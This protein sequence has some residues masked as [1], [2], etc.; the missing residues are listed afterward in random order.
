MPE[1]S[2]FSLHNILTWESAEA[3][4]VQLLPQVLV[5]TMVQLYNCHP[6]GSQRIVPTRQ[7]PEVFCC[8]RDSV[9][10]TCAGGC[11]VE[12]FSVGQEL[13]QPV[14]SFNTLGRVVH[15]SYSDVGDYLV[16]IEE[17]NNICSLR[18]Y[19]N[20]RCQTSGSSRVSVRMLG[21]QLE[22]FQSGISK[23]QMEIIEMPLS[24][25]P[26]CLSCCPVRGDLLVSCTSKLVVFNLKYITIQDTT[27]LDFDR[28]LVLHINGVVPSQLSF[29][30]WYIGL[31]NDLEVLVL[32]L[33]SEPPRGTNISFK[34]ATEVETFTDKGSKNG[35]VAP[36]QTLECEH[37]VLCHRP[38]ELIGEDCKSCNISVTPEPAGLSP[39]AQSHCHVEYIMY[40]RFAPDFSDGFNVEST[41]L[42]SL[43]FLPL[44]KTVNH[45][46]ATNAKNTTSQKE[47]SSLFCFFSMPHVGFLYTL[48]HS[49]ELISVYQY[50]ERSQQAVLTPQFL[51]VIT[52]N[53]L[54]C[55]T[56]R[57]S[58]A[59]AREEDPYIDTTMKTAHCCPSTRVQ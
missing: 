33:S 26:Q 38:V 19:V 22:S 2:F 31:A 30:S 35:L 29:C 7:A 4:D 21:L 17:K 15:M 45:L 58:A 54:Q 53:N 57:C 48:V 10:V 56:V 20:W 40:R 16:T 3:C 43:Q 37:F 1:A 18:A 14:C 23:D 49:V 28:S 42:H 11:K 8:G 55:Y 52:S 44:Y 13:C 51:H 47:M 36:S 50:P 5:S 27:V 41:R 32:R 39:D 46:P 25:N 24:E 6:F 59:A 9:F 12:V 34:N